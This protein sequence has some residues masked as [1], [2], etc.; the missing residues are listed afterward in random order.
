[1]ERV[2]VLVRPPL[3]AI[4]TLIIYL[5]W[6]IGRLSAWSSPDTSARW[7]RFVYRTWA[8]VGLWGLGVRCR[9]RGAPPVG[10]ALIAANHQC[11]LD[12]LILAAVCGANLVSKAEV[13]EW[14]VFGYMARSMGTL[15]LERTRKRD[16]IGVNR[17]LRAALERG[18]CMAFFPEGTTSD[19]RALLPFRPGLFEPAVELG[20]AVVPVA[21]RLSPAPGR[22][23][24]RESLCWPAGVS[25]ATHVRTL[26]REPSIEVEV[27]IGETPRRAADRKHLAAL[28]RSDVER[29][30]R[31]NRGAAT[32][33]ELE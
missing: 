23:T 28:V 18:D 22:S 4:W 2:R 11:V 1:M 12:T 10:A 7:R 9:V 6:L 24:A 8:R 26:L 25:L 31:S 5:A 15:F 21:I 33:A 17:A 16:L 19:G 20:I 13:G 29:L 30:W 32:A 3:F 27:A 14:P